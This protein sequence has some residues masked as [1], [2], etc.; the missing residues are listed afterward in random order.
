VGHQHQVAAKRL[1][2]PAE[3]V[4]AAVSGSL[5]KAVNCPARVLARSV[6]V[7]WLGHDRVF[8]SRGEPKVGETRAN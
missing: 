6:C 7:V 5:E 8:R 2:D 1:E 4:V 3:G